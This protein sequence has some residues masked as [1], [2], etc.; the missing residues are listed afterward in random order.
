VKKAHD[1]ADRFW[2][3]HFLAKEPPRNPE[4]KQRSYDRVNTSQEE[5]RRVRQAERL[6]AKRAAE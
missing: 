1:A 5:Q 2:L 6:R 3:Q 4:K